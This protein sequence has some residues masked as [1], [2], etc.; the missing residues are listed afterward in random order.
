[1]TRQQDERSYTCFSDKVVIVTGSG[2]QN[3]NLSIG[4]AIASSFGRQGAYTCILDID[5]ARAEET[6]ELIESAGGAARSYLVD[7]TDE[8]DCQRCVADIVSRKGRIDVLVNNVG[9][10]GQMVPLSQVDVSKWSRTIDA[11]LKSAVIMSKLVVPSME[12]Q[13]EGSIINISS[14]SGRV[15]YGLPAY[16]PSKAALTAFTKELAV[17]YGRMGIRANSI[18]PGHLWTPW[19]EA[20]S[21]D[22]Q[23]R[24]RRDIA[25]LNIEGEARDVASAALFLASTD[26]RFITGAE[27]VVDGGVT[28]AGSMAAYRLAVSS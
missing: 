5:L 17:L 18:A 12:R 11:N 10:G 2:S 27:L 25:P 28:A 8:D 15:A 13:R 23:R 9:V 1:M 6:R 22:D 24:L 7:V 4:S 3:G 16:G 20:V 21:H 14:I 26:A 19:A